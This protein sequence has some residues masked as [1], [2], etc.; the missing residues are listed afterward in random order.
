MII[1]QVLSEII[2]HLTEDP[3]DIFSPDPPKDLGSFT[4]DIWSCF[5]GL[6]CDISLKLPLLE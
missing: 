6:K 5:L 3:K 1:L 2:K 4:L